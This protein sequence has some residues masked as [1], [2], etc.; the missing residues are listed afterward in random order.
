[1]RFREPLDHVRLDEALKKKQ[2]QQQLN[3]G[4]V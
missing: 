2:Q 4:H 3:D 1:M